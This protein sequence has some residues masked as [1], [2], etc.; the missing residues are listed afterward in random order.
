M[1]DHKHFTSLIGHEDF[2]EGA[3]CSNYLFKFSGIL[4]E[5]HED[6]YDGYRSHLDKITYASSSKNIICMP[7]LAKV[8]LERSEPVVKE[9]Q[10]IFNGY[11][12]VDVNTGHV[13][14]EVGT[15]YY[16]QWYPFFVFK[17]NAKL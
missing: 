4:W 1:I 11:R 16:D 7:Q 15:M 5:A 6:E 2:Y 9:D 12:L 10:E 13:W 8:K 14:L 17:H 3:D